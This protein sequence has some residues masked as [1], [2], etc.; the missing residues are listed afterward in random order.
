MFRCFVMVFWGN[1]RENILRSTRINRGIFRA[2]TKIKT[3]SGCCQRVNW[4]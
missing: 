4:S 2:T 1:A 3:G